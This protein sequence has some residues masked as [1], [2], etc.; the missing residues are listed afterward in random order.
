MTDEAA[1]VARAECVEWQGCRLP[2]GY[3]RRKYKG[4][5]LLAHRLAYCEHHGLELEDIGG[6]VVRHRCDSPS[7]VNPEHL[8]L[9]THADNMQDMRERGRSARLQGTANGSAK[10]TEEDVLAI[11][12][13]YVPRCRAHGGKA[14][15]RKYGVS[16]QIVSDIITRRKWTHI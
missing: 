16:Q 15:A 1:T 11:R 5:D 2:A 14:L 9:G 8:E 4:K 3:G 7:C 12:E 13:E 6:K 10:L